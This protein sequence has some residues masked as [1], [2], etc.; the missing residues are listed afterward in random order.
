ML[1]TEV[2]IEAM[3]RSARVRAMWLARELVA[4]EADNWGC[5][6][7]CPPYLALARW[8]QAKKIAK[9]GLAVESNG[10]QFVVY[11]ADFGRGY[12]NV[13]Q[14]YVWAGTQV[15]VRSSV[16]VDR[17]LPRPALGPPSHEEL[18]QAFDECLD[19]VALISRLW[20]E[21]VACDFGYDPEKHERVEEA[22]AA[23]LQ[24]EW[25]GLGTP[26]D[27][28]GMHADPFR[29]KAWTCRAFKDTTGR[30]ITYVSAL[31]PFT[32]EEDDHGR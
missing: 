10:G 16:R 19:G 18:A 8:M 27:R 14:P 17:Q 13:C 32:H 11:D 23:Y 12:A 22:M 20:A 1:R 24:R 30:T 4:R 21:G 9:G 31:Q 6:S 2:P 26:F 28:I 15:A 3:Y 25:V 29:F 5:P 7:S